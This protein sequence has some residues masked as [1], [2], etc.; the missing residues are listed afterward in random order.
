MR[1]RRGRKGRGRKG[2]KAFPIL[3]AAPVIPGVIAVWNSRGSGP[4]EAVRQGVGAISGVDIKGE[5]PINYPNAYKTLGLV[6]IGM[7]GH[8]IA[9][10]TGINRQLKKLSMGYIQL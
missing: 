2:G 5:S 9:N 8:K 10:K 1:R 6:I 4:V 3:L 7:V